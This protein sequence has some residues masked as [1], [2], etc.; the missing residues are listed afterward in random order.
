MRSIRSS[1]WLLVA[2]ASAASLGCANV[3]VNKVSVED[4]LSGNDLNVKGFR[5][6]LNRPYVVVGRQISA[7][8]IYVPVIPVKQIA[9]IQK[10]SPAKTAPPADE[11]YLRFLAAVSDDE[12]QGSFRVYDSE[13]HW[14]DTV[15]HG[16]Y[17]YGPVQITPPDPPAKP[18]AGMAFAA[19]QPPTNN[20]GTTDQ[21]TTTPPTQ[22]ADAIQVLFLPDFEEQYAIYNK[23]CQ[24]KTKYKY[25]FNNGT[26]LVSMAGS[27]NSTDVPVMLVE[28]VGQLLQAAGQIAM[29]AVQP[30]SA[31]THA[32]APSGRH[33][34]AAD[35]TKDLT[36][37][38]PIMY[39][40]KIEQ[41]LEPGIYRVQKSW[42]QVAHTPVGGLS[43]PQF[44]CLFADIGLEIREVTSIITSTQHDKETA[45]PTTATTPP[46]KNA[47]G[48]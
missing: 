27:Y 8:T 35:G 34:F 21:K 36:N 48:Q 17:A 46:S 30:A 13:G 5:Y 40:L 42:E 24:A 1:A 38:N 16:Q 22:P 3:K 2:A 33:N 45:P 44:A 37:A 43:P 47:S 25:T 7:G 10:P 19:N 12:N 18:P 9:A 32:A 31:L 26:E 41:V 14:V 23:N 4:R 6:Y 11:K 15:P 28:T 39:Y 20:P 29:T